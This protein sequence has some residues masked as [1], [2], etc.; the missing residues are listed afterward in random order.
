MRI[1]I[2]LCAFLFSLSAV[3][4]KDTVKAQVYSWKNLKP[5]KEETRERRQVLEGSTTAFENL[6]IHTTTLEPGKAPHPPH[7]HADE[8]ELIIVKEA[9]L[10]GR[11]NRKRPAVAIFMSAS[12]K[13]SDRK[14][15]S[16]QR[17]TV[18]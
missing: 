9:K 3:V 11:K 4:Q 6:E 1:F 13:L 2:A 18:S 7:V 14:F 10:V 5:V 12:M 16:K 8:E 17:R 15:S